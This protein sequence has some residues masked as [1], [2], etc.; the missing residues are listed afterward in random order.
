MRMLYIVR[1]VAKQWQ[2]VIDGTPSFWTIILST[3]PL[4][5]N[6]TTIMRSENLPLLVVYEYVT[7]PNENHHPSPEQFLETVAHTRF[8][9]S[10]LSLDISDE[11]C[12]P[13]YLEAPAPLL[14]TLVVSGPWDDVVD[15]EP[16]ELLGGQTS[17]LK[18]VSIS[19]ASF[20]CR[21]GLF[22]GLKALLLSRV[23]SNLTTSHIV[24]ILR[25]SPCL[26]ELRVEGDIKTV[27]PQVSSSFIILSHLRS[28]EIECNGNDATDCILQR[29]R[30]PSCISFTVS[31][32]IGNEDYYQHFMNETLNPFQ[33]V[34]RTIHI[35]N[36]ASEVSVETFGFYWRSLV[37]AN[38]SRGFSIWMDGF[39][40]LGVRWVG[41]I[42]QEEPGLRIDMA[43]NTVVSEA[44][45]RDMAP[46][47]CVT[48]LLVSIDQVEEVRMVLRFLC[49]P[50]NPSASL[51]SL[52]CLR[53]FVILSTCWSTHNL[54]DIVQSRLSLFS[55]SFLHPP[56]LAINV[57]PQ[58]FLWK[59]TPRPFIDLIT[60]IKIRET[61]GVECVKLLGEPN[62]A[63]TL[64]VTW[65]EE[66]S[67]PN[68]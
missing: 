54:L 57:F 8:R 1:Q 47:R 53:E 2:E 19:D 3:L 36:G 61:E 35:E 51:P 13:G 67:K 21:M 9:W 63:G 20:Q 16:L 52:P 59:R 42:L 7:A 26:E 62:V 28:I 66:A 25:A 64:A 23:R 34:L 6:N 68:G 5:V 43:Y 55:K 33:G 14:Q 46:L 49:Q 40:P 27:I 29:I 60:L 4:H 39:N 32:G 58:A 12:M 48:R 30:A 15:T 24:D 10:A 37:A 65:N 44:I 56:P 45:L 41:Q 38:R 18:Y 31:V 22:T 11:T 17:N 50:L